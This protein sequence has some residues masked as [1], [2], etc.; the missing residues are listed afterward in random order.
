M[1]PQ[2]TAQQRTRTRRTVSIRPANW[3]DMETVANFLRSTA[4][5]YRPFLREEDMAEH[6]VPDSWKAANFERRDFYMGFV[7]ET[8]VGTISLQYFGDHAYVGYVYLDAAFVGNGYGR[9]LLEFAAGLAREKGMKGVALIAHP[10]ATWA[11]RAYV[12]F[13]FEKVASDREDVLAWNDGAL[14]D[15]YEDGFELYVYPLD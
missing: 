1:S 11:T 13:G 15:F 10:E 6:D 9:Q 12:K 2:M 4:D 7:G 8:A 5:W 3:D 14:K